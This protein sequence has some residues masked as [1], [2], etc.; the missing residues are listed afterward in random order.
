MIEAMPPLKQPDGICARA[1]CKGSSNVDSPT[2]AEMQPQAVR[3]RVPSLSL[4]II[5]PSFLLFVQSCQFAPTTPVLGFPFWDPLVY[6]W[7]L[8]ILL[9][10]TFCYR[11]WS[12]KKWLRKSPLAAEIVLCAGHPGTKEEGQSP[13]RDRKLYLIT[14]QCLAVRHLARFPAL[15]QISRKGHSR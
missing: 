10:Q 15:L 1:F 2:R 5:S 14:L 6:S 9:L 8:W 13:G 4:I 12:P 11:K 3:V 7:D